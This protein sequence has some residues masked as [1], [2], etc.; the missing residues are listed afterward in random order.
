MKLQKALRTELPGKIL[1]TVPKK[2]KQSSTASAIRNGIT[3]GGSE[4]SSI[5]STYTNATTATNATNATQRTQGR[6]SIT[7]GM[8]N[9][10]VQGKRSQL[11]ILSRTDFQL[12]GGR[13]RSSS[14]SL[15]VPSPSSARSSGDARSVNG[16]S[17][18]ISAGADDDV[19]SSYSGLD[20]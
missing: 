13:K 15:G 6:R 7:G 11:R 18:P 8:Q 20:T 16:D 4:R 10:E 2:N 14:T 3:G 9:L 5:S 12:G 1:P 19:R 17:P